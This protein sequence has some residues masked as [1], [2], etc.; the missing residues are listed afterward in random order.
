MATGNHAY[1][2]VSA[3]LEVTGGTVDNATDRTAALIGVNRAYRRFLHGQHPSSPGSVHPWSFLRPMGAIQIPEYITGTGTGTFLTGSTTIVDDD[4]GDLFTDGTHPA[5]EIGVGILVDSVGLLRITAVSN[6]NTV[7]ALG[8]IGDFTSKTFYTGVQIDM[9]DDFGG[10]VTNFYYPRDSANS[11]GPRFAEVSAELMMLN[12]QGS[13][14]PST[15]DTFALIPMALTATVGQRYS[16]IFWPLSDT[17]RVVQYRYRSVP[18]D[19]T[20][21]NTVYLAG[22][23]E[24]SH[25]IEMAVRADAEALTRSGKTGQYED[26]FQ[27]AMMG[28]INRDA[29]MFNTHR[30]PRIVEA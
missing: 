16:V 7:V 20:D 18:A 2:M 22:G 19:L 10:L 25:T 8:G 15:P 21:V 23:V 28:S 24:H 3:Y 11:T 1:Y 17:D 29:T 26:A 9:P 6:T 14:S 4:A 5:G 30:T 27:L 12:L 13:P